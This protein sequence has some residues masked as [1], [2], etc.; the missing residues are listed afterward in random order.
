MTLPADTHLPGSPCQAPRP[1]RALRP[2]PALGLVL[3]ASVQAAGPAE[4][5]GADLALGER[6]I[7]QHRCT[8][9]HVQK[10]GGDGSAIYRPAGRISRPSALL[11]MVEMCSTELKLQLFPEDVAAVAAVLQR[12]HYRFK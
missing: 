1:W 5:A 9:C 7:R 2:W 3:A 4:F 6:L 12:D 10:V 8:E 11:S